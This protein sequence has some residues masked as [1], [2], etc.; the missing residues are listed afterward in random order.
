M[1]AFTGQ[2]LTG[3]LPVVFPETL[4]LESRKV[5]G[6]FGLGLESRLESLGFRDFFTLGK[7]LPTRKNIVEI[8]N[9]LTN[10]HLFRLLLLVIF[11]SSYRF[12]A[13][14]SRQ[15]CPAQYVIYCLFICLL[16]M[17]IVIGRD[18]IQY[19]NHVFRKMNNLIDE[20]DFENETNNNFIDDELE[21]EIT[22]DDSE[23]KDSDEKVDE[24]WREKLDLTKPK[25]S[26]LR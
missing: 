8:F 13:H 4:G 23:T 12:F 18:W 24:K 15:Y 21:P 25:N 17:V 10:F 16:L 7:M 26:F 5:S 19:Y 1:I 3:H 2:I 9:I 22:S 6:F 14:P 20:F 11:S